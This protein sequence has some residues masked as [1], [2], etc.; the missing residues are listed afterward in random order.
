MDGPAF[1]FSK[2]LPEKVGSR[3]E[4]KR[5]DKKGFSI[6]KSEE[7]LLLQHCSSLAHV[8]ISQPAA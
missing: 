5:D 3:E 4:V 2:T 8:A 6:H 1:F 7:V